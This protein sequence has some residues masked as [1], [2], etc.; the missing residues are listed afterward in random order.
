MEPELQIVI[1]RVETA[2][3]EPL[4]FQ[5]FPGRLYVLSIPVEKYAAVKATLPD[6]DI[7]DGIACF[8]E[9]DDAVQFMALPSP[10]SIQGRITSATFDEAR[11]IALSR[12]N[13][14][15]LVLYVK[16]RLVDYHFVR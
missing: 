9:P 14:N 2:T 11:A 16:G 10:K 8:P 13:L 1:K 15:S 3:A 5:G 7:L 6:L 12:P 4:G